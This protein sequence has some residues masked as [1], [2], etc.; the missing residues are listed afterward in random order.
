M[1][2]LVYLTS[3]TMLLIDWG[4][5]RYIATHPDQFRENNPLLGRHPSLLTVDVYFTTAIILIAVIT[6]ILPKQYR[7]WWLGGIALLETG[8]VIHNHSIGIGIFI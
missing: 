6:W 4:Q 8:L 3:L 1:K 7:I 2:I 5:T